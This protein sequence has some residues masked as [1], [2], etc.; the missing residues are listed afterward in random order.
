MQSLNVRLENVHFSFLLIVSICLRIGEPT[1]YLHVTTAWHKA[2]RESGLAQVE[3]IHKKV[4]VV[5]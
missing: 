4:K 1:L 5:I 2:I 3:I